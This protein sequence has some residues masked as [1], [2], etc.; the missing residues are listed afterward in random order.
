MICALP[1]YKSK[2]SARTYS[3]QRNGPYQL[4]MRVCISSAGTEI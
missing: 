4:E 2:H 1:D 3:A